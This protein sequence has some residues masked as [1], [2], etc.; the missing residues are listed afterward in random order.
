M[1][2]KE[3]QPTE[4]CIIRVLQKAKPKNNKY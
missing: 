4:N 1:G 2:K 3:K